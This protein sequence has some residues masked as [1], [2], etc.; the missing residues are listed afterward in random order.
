MSDSITPNALPDDFDPFEHLQSVYIPQH[1]KAVKL[2]FSD[3]ADDWQPNIA[4]PRSSLRTA[5]TMRDEDNQ[6][7]MNLRHHLLFDLLGY[8]KQVIYGLPSFELH[9]T[10]EFLPQCVLWFR[11]KSTEAKTHG[12]YPARAR[13]SF[14]I[15]DTNFTEVE[16]KALALKIKEIFATPKIIF[17]KG[18]V[19]ISY[20]DLIQ[21][22]EFILAAHNETE[23]K[24]VI[25][26][27][28]SLR[29][30][31]PNW[32]NLTNSESG[33]HFQT[34]KYKLILGKETQMPNRRPIANCLFTH[35]ELKIH[36]MVKD[37]ILCDTTGRYPAAYE[38]AFS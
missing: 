31:E 27:V 5:C 30:H 34:K 29:S 33:K 24:E 2:F 38:Y 7:M 10:R 32:E 35:A 4:S 28:L 23:A 12:R 9:E 11:E 17:K 3:H 8:G 18:E 15:T 37:K 13:I 26:K 1:N 25:T 16:A 20:R 14:R 6:L 22:Y 21:G 36:G 19:K